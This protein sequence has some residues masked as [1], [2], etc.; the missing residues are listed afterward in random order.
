MT[1]ATNAPHKPLAE[2]AEGGLGVGTRNAP[3]E[4]QNPPSPLQNDARARP[5][6]VTT[7]MRV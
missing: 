2:A 6:A 5:A 1:P 4:T 3:S 7:E